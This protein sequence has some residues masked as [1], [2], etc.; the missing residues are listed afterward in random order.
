M[1][2]NYSVVQDLHYPDLDHL[3]LH[4]ELFTE[5]MVVACGN[6]PPFRKNSYLS[7][8]DVLSEPYI[9]RLKCEFRKTFL[10]EAQRRGFEA[11]IV[12]RSHTWS[13]KIARSCSV[14]VG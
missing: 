2:P 13:F 11:P 8:E 7:L 12:A 10:V 6:W 1:R 5:R 4:V 3:Q 14:V 9:D